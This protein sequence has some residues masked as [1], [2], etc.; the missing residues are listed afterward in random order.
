MQSLTRPAHPLKPA[1]RGSWPAPRH[2]APAIPDMSYL[3]FMTGAL[4]QWA[5]GMAIIGALL[6]LLLLSWVAAPGDSYL[7]VRHDILA[8]DILLPL[9]KAFEKQGSKSL[10]E[11]LRESMQSTML[12]FKIWSIA[13]T[14]KQIVYLLGSIMLAVA[15]AFVGPSASR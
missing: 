10:S 8:P 14:T 13:W 12:S 1:D 5:I 11:A 4:L 6:T 9:T 7:R 15:L 3:D 2:T